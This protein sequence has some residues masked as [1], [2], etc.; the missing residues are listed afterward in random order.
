M[1][2]VFTQ[3]T[4]SPPASIIIRSMTRAGHEASLWEIMSFVPSAT[5][6]AVG[7]FAAASRRS[8]TPYDSL[9]LRPRL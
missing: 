3:S 2:V 8:S 9:V 1:N 4:G 7:F 5:T 6:I